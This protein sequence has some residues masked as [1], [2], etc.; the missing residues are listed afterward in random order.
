MKMQAA[1]TY[2]FECLHLHGLC[3]WSVDKN[4]ETSDNPLISDEVACYMVALCR[5][6]VLVALYLSFWTML[7]SFL[8][9]H[10]GVSYEF[11]G[12]IVGCLASYVKTSYITGEPNARSDI[13]GVANRWLQEEAALGSIHCCFPLSAPVWWSSLHPSQRYWIQFLSRNCST[14]INW[15]KTHQHGGMFVSAYTWVWHV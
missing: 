12:Y 10:R 1:M 14:Y 2:C 15:Q 7:I 6:K 5:Q 13:G 3:N 8:D 4:G 9:T 11:P